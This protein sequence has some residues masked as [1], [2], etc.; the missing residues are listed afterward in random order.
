VTNTAPRRRVGFNYHDALGNTETLDYDLY[1]KSTRVTDPRGGTA[2]AAAA[3]IGFRVIFITP[4][5]LRGQQKQ[6]ADTGA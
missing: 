5:P 6:R 2:S 1:R 3:P 4:P